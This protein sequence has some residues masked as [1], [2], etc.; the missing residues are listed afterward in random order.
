MPISLRT[1]RFLVCA[2]KI[3]E[4]I[5]KKTTTIYPK[6]SV[7]VLISV[8]QVDNWMCKYLRL[9][10]FRRAFRTRCIYWPVYCNHC[11][12]LVR[13]TCAT[14]FRFG[15]FGAIINTG[16]HDSHVTC[17]ANIPLQNVLNFCPIMHLVSHKSVRSLVKRRTNLVNARA[18]EREKAKHT[19][20]VIFRKY[21][22]LITYAVCTV[23]G[24]GGGGGG[25]DN[26]DDWHSQMPIRLLRN[27]MYEFFLAGFGHCI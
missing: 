5:Q 2:T 8:K 13:R 1:N 20:A 22:K 6:F 17:L 4:R 9:I 25:N 26:G 23:G 24:G 15:I 3:N 27:K 16:Q 12:C 19:N 11:T 7:I 14:H 21:R 10:W 18:K